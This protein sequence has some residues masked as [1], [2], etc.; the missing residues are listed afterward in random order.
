MVKKYEQQ[1]KTK[2]SNSLFFPQV[3][4]CR[5]T[6]LALDQSE[7]IAESGPEPNSFLLCLA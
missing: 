7:P 5:R 2:W 3:K 6:S 1:E 4:D